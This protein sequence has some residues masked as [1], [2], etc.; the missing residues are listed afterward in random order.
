MSLNKLN[1]QSVCSYFHIA[2]TLF[3]FCTIP[4]YYSKFLQYGLIFFFSSFA[5]DYLASKRW[6]EGFKFDA[7]RIVSLL[8]LL[9]FV[10]LFVFSFFEQDTRYL[11]TLYEYRL[12]FLG[13]GIVGLLGVSDKFRVRHFA[14]ASVIVFVIFLCWI[15]SILPDYFPALET[16]KQKLEVLLVYR[17]LKI[18]SHMTINIFFCVGMI[19]FSKVIETSKNKLEKA[20]SVFM[21][22]AF[23]FLVLL[24]EA[25]IGMLNATLVLIFIILRFAIRKLKIL[26]PTLIVFLLAFSGVGLFILS[27]NP[28][29]KEVAVLN[30]T[31]PREYI[32]QDGVELIKE[33]PILGVGASTNALRV[34][35]RLLANEELCKIEWF[36]IMHL[37][38]EHVFAMHTHNQIMQSWQEYGIIGLFAIL[39]LFAFILWASRESLSLNLIFAIIFVQLITDVI[40]AGVTAMGFCFYVYL[41][42]VL[43]KSCEM[44]RKKKMTS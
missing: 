17:S 31:N 41:I 35:E 12:S 18:S 39:S 5:F 19:L 20:F 14:Y 9:Q 23:Y 4:F 21:I 7:A 25:R 24:T 36:L 11:S 28:L 38:K 34:K 42:F 22:V 15:Y 2:S 13:F 33:S 8:L 29:K 44:G 26:I 40:D 3:L 27:D 1:I 32:W 16:L 6:K 10:L 30:K 37:K 43:A